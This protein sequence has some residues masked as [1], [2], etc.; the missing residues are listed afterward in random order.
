[1]ETSAASSTPA[2][3]L[4]LKRKAD[5]SHK[6]PAVKKLKKQTHLEAFFANYPRFHDDP[7]SPVSAQYEHGT[8]KSERESKAAR[9][10]T[11][12][13]YQPAMAR[14]FAEIF[15]E[16]VNDLSNWQSLCRVLEIDPVPQNLHAC[17]A[18]VREIH[19]N[20]VDLV[21]WGGTGA[22]LPSSTRCR[23]LRSRPR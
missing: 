15:G 16:D 21:D 22:R 3:P 9:E 11:Y 13:G 17:R 20:L 6:P 7:I 19:V 4:S 2:V 5:W 18:A 8:V 1:M 14:T 12:A 10:A 23:N